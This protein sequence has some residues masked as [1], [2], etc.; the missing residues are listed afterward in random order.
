MLNP[1][2]YI[3]AASLALTGA[4]RYSFPPPAEQTTHEEPQAAAQVASEVRPGI[5]DGA[6][7]HRLVAQGIVV[8][9]VRTRTEFEARHVPGA[10]NIPVD[11][12]V[13]RAAEIGPRST[14]ALLYCRSGHRSAIARDALQKLGYTALYDMRTLAAW[15]QSAAPAGP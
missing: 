6:T 4:C 12:I 8:V 9:D 13:A 11:Q 5:V 1:K 2:P 10:K 14:P 3:A 7:A 15:E